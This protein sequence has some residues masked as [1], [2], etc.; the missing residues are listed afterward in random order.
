MPHW[1]DIEPAPEPQPS[2]H[3][4]QMYRQHQHI[5]DALV[6]F[7]L[8]VVFGRPESVV[9]QTIHKLRHG[10]R[11]V[12]DRHEMLVGKAAVVDGRSSVSDVVYVD[13]ACIQTIEFGNHAAPPHVGNRWL[14]AALYL[15]PNVRQ[16]PVCG[17]GHEAGNIIGGSLLYGITDA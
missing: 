11:F 12:E 14:S 17:R 6:A 13:M 15:I 4:R 2:R 1:G 5:G 9:A 3:M 8:K 7:V 10:L 16:T